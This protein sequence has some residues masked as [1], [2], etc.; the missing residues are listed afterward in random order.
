MLT[1]ISS[2]GPIAANCGL[3]DQAHLTS[4]LAGMSVKVRAPDIVL[5]FCSLNVGAQRCRE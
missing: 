5:I 1:N 2:V 4:Y 3:A